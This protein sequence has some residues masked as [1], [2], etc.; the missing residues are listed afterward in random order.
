[1]MT[2]HDVLMIAAVLAPGK[3][4]LADDAFKR[5]VEL[6]LRDQLARAGGKV[7]GPFAKRRM[8]HG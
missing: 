6:L 7:S 8:N 3:Y 2:Q 5:E 1:M 4:P